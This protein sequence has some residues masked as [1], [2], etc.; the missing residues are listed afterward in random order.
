MVSLL[1]VY[2]SLLPNL[3]SLHF[4]TILTNF[5]VKRLNLTFTRG[6]WAKFGHLKL[7]RLKQNET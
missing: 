3:V 1:K 7:H 4:P 6:I 5:N 2:V